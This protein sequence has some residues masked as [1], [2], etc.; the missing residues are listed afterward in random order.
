[1]SLMCEQ[2]GQVP[3]GSGVVALARGA[4]SRAAPGPRGAAGEGS[5]AARV[6]EGWAGVWNCLP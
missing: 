1:M 2:D 6:T 3:A 5:L 4:L